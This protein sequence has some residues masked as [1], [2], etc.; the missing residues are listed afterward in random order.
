MTNCEMLPMAD[1]TF[2]PGPPSEDSIELARVVGGEFVE[3]ELV[4]FG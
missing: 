2:E 1:P 3:S 4:D